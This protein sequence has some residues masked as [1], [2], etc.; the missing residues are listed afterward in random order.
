MSFLLLL[1]RLFLQ[2]LFNWLLAVPLPDPI[3]AF[4]ISRL[5]RLRWMS[6]RSGT[7]KVICS[8]SLKMAS[9]SEN[10]DRF[11]RC[12]LELPSART[13]HGGKRLI[14]FLHNQATMAIYL[15]K[16]NHIHDEASFPLRKM[17]ERVTYLLLK[18]PFL[19]TFPGL[20]DLCQQSNNWRSCANFSS[21]C[22]QS[23][24]ITKLLRLH[25]RR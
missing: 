16:S 2:I 8:G 10:N 11:F 5:S 23:R 22:F 4:L 21:I 1:G 14:A 15:F 3:S 25:H 19:R 9:I 20:V 17:L 7:L 6:F 13:C 18:L 12:L 24:L